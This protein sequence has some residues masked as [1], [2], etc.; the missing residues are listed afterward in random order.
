M[1]SV[2]ISA[3]SIHAYYLLFVLS[4]SNKSYQHALYSATLS[5]FT[6]VNILIKL[7]KIFP[8]Q[9]NF[10]TLQSACRYDP[11]G[12]SCFSTGMFRQLM[13]LLWY[14]QQWKR[15]NR[16]SV[17]TVIKISLGSLELLIAIIFS[18]FWCIHSS[19]IILFRRKHGF[20]M[21]VL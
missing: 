2:Q 6:C 12:C 13:P 9:F 10:V 3:K 16:G 15:N 18:F 5:P 21:A 4:S 1:R 7:L 20:S 17:I 8:Q 11:R 19:L 14:L